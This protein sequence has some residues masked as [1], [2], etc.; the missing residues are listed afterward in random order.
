[1]RD[2]ATH[3]NLS[4]HVIKNWHNEPDDKDFTKI[5]KECDSQVYDMFKV[6]VE[7]EKAWANLFKE[8]TIGLNETYYT[9]TLNLLQT[10]IKSN[11]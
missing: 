3:L 8:G 5:A 10:K 6:A 9:D 2:E 1:M 7:E 11:W 4:T